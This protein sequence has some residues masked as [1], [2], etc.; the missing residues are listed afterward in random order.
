MAP[1]RKGL[2]PVPKRADKTPL[3]PSRSILLQ[4]GYVFSDE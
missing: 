3:T 1:A 4:D 2:T